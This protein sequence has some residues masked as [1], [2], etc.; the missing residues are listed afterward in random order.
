M[1]IAGREATEAWKIFNQKFIW[2]I[3]RNQGVWARAGMQLKHMQMVVSAGQKFGF[4]WLGLGTLACSS[5]EFRFSSIFSQVINTH[6]NERQERS[7]Y[8]ARMLLC[9]TVGSNSN[10]RDP[11]KRCELCNMQFCMGK[12]VQ[13]LHT[14]LPVLAVSMQVNFSLFLSIR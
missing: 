5:F 4:I 8:N 9:S 11:V 14:V 12:L 1:L 13:R 3:F 10:T 2:S 7:E 6:R